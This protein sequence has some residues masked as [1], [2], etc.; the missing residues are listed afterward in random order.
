MPNCHKDQASSDKQQ[1]ASKTNPISSRPKTMRNRHPSRHT[2]TALAFVAFTLHS[3]FLIKLDATPTNRPPNEIT[4]KMT[5]LRNIQYSEAAGEK[6]Y[7]DLFLPKDVENPKPVLLIHGGA[8]KSM[9]RQRNNEVAVFLATQGYAVFNVSYRLIPDAPY[10]ACKEDCSEA[11][12]FLLES[13][14]PAMKSLDRR[15]IVVGGLSAGGHL[16]L[17]TGLELSEDKI[18][19]ILDICGPTELTAP[20]VAGLMSFS[21]MAHGDPNKESI[22]K[23]ASPT[24]LASK[25]ESLPPLLVLHCQQDGVVD[26]RQAYRIIEVWNQAGANLQAFLYEGS[27]KKGHNIWRNSK[28]EPDLYYKLESQIIA[29]LDSFFPQKK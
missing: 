26:I 21:G 28:A 24:V 16:A 3:L 8:W 1:N 20:E 10:P 27:K 6:G 25:R 11:A 17:V 7:G 18:A 4:E 19:G 13:D 15:Q 9:T 14:H 29:F 2:I 12:K 5:I 23:E 22:Y